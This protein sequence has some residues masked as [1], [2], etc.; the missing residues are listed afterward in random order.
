MRG[1]N[2]NYD[3][4]SD[5]TLVVNDFKYFSFP[6]ISSSMEGLQTSYKILLRNIN[7]SSDNS[8]NFKNGDDQKL[9]SSILLDTSLPLKKDGENFKSFLTPR[10]SA[11]YSPNVTKNNFKYEIIFKRFA[12]IEKN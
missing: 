11:R 6:K 7:S 5:E 10:I 8:S 2:K 4:N 3:T 12:K 9:L 1:F